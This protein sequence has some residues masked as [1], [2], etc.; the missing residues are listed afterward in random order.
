MDAHVVRIIDA[1]F[2]GDADGAQSRAGLWSLRSDG[3]VAIERR[4]GSDPVPS[5]NSNSRTSMA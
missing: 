5:E 2:A 3:R 1:L 4:S